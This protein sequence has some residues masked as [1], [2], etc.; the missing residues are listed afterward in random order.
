MKI[1]E[2]P[3]VYSK[4]VSETE[5]GTQQVRLTVNEFRGV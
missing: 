2:A 5:D 4:V 1:Y 3:E